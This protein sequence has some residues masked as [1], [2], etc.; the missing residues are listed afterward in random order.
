MSVGE[1]KNALYG[2]AQLVTQLSTV[3]ERLMQDVDQ[4]GWNESYLEALK[5]KEEIQSQLKVVSDKDNLE[6]VKAKL[7]AISKK[8]TR[9]R[10]AK[11]QLQMEEPLRE[12]RIAEKDAAVEMWRKKKIQEAEEKKKEQELKEVADAVLCDIRKKLSDVKRAQDIL[13]SLENL[14]KLRKEAT[15]R[16]GIHTDL[17]SDKAFSSLLEELRSVAKRRLTLYGREEKTLMVMLEG[18]QEEE[19]KRVLELQHKKDKDRHMRRKR[20]IESMMFGEDT[21]P[22]PFMQP[23][24]QYYTQAQESLPAL[25]QIRREWDAFLVPADHPEGWSVP[26]GWVF[27][28]P[29][30]DQ[31]WAEALHTSDT[32]S[33]SLQSVTVNTSLSHRV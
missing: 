26:L 31:S 4:N 7:T 12:A 21:P 1:M 3:C 28:E 8:R 10:K 33:A 6:K 23:F 22:D 13:K 19:R 24:R 25:V 5:M 16:K 32:D 17:Q 27:P 20:K 14:R 2:T 29:P 11:L 9:K 15:M 30:S 18:E